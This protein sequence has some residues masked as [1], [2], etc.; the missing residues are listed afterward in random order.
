MT[1]TVV[2]ATIFLGMMG[3]IFVIG[4]SV[5][6]GWQSIVHIWRSYGRL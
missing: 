5:A 2:F 4:G 3:A 6:T 1:V